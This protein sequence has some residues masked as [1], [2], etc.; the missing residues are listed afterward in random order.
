MHH[1]NVLAVRFEL[2]PRSHRSASL[3]R[4]KNDKSLQSSMSLTVPTDSNGKSH[5]WTENPSG[6]IKDIKIKSYLLNTFMFCSLYHRWSRDPHLRESQRWLRSI[7]SSNGK[8]LS[9]LRKS[10]HSLK[11]ESACMKPLRC[12]NIT[13][14]M[15]STCL[16]SSQ[17]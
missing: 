3:T 15:N 13:V 11:S 8:Y 14:A 7:S 17:Q 5:E 9:C 4:I 2:Q 1:Q 10:F 6:E 16:T 12:R